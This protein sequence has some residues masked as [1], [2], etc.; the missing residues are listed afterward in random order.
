MAS[1]VEDPRAHRAPPK[2]S[3]SSNKAPI[4]APYQETYRKLG[5]LGLGE[6]EVGVGALLLG[7]GHGLHKG[8]GQQAGAHAAE[9]S[10]GLRQECPAQRH[11]VAWL[12]AARQLAAD[13]HHHAAWCR[14]LRDL[15]GGGKRV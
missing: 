13:L 9:A 12:A 10:E 4:G 6:G 3:S 5:A 15:Q 8:G 2:F 11:G 1:L 7:D 14:P